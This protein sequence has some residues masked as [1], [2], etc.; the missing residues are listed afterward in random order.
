M[1]INLSIQVTNDIKPDKWFNK[2]IKTQVLN[3]WKYITFHAIS[4]MSFKHIDI[5]LIRLGRGKSDEI[6]TLRT[7][8]KLP[9]VCRVPSPSGGRCSKAQPHTAWSAIKLL[10]KGALFHSG[11]GWSSLNVSGV[12]ECKF[13]NLKVSFASFS[14]LHNYQKWQHIMWCHISSSILILP[15]P[16]PQTK[17]KPL[18]EELAWLVPSPLPVENLYPW[19]CTFVLLIPYQLKFSLSN[20][21]TH[22]RVG[23]CG[24]GGGVWAMKG[25]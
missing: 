9:E 10:D 23:V 15:P 16:P 22:D 7:F 5:T 6:M 3:R 20:V 2:I 21:Q 1:S 24:G 4:P 17:R 14:M 19:N 13:V 18:F 25:R 8:L 12:L 11:F